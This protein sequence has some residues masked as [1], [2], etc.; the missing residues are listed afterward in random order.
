MA[1]RTLQGRLHFHRPKLFD[2]EVEMGDCCDAYPAWLHGVQFRAPNAERTWNIH[3]WTIGGRLD[4]R[5]RIRETSQYAAGVMTI[6]YASA[7][8]GVDSPASGS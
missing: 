4:L 8:R 5:G 2:R 3:E 1:K 7:S 6:S